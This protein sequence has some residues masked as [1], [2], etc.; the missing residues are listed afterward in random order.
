MEISHC[1]TNYCQKQPE[2]LLNNH[3]ATRLRAEFTLF[4]EKLPDYV[5]CF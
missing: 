1:L 3:S 2:N 4:E 5:K